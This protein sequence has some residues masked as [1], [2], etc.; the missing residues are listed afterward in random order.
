MA[1]SLDK[2]KW[3]E[4]DSKEEEV[5]YGRQTGKREEKEWKKKEEKRERESDRKE[6][7]TRELIAWIKNRKPNNEHCQSGGA[8]VGVSCTLCFKETVAVDFYITFF[9]FKVSGVMLLF[10]CLVLHAMF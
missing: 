7:R 2:E 9:C 10:V 8:A 3:M 6:G 5:K 4:R 1:E